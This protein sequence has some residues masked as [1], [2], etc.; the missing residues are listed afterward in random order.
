[1]DIKLKFFKEAL[2]HY[3][4]GRASVLA[5][6]HTH[7]QTA[8]EKILPNGTAYITDLGMTGIAD[9]I[10]GMEP[11]TCIQRARKQVLYRMEAAEKGQKKSVQGII[12]EIDG[13]SGRAVGI[14]R[15]C[16]IK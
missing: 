15:F 12:A 8:D 11:E 9:G 4:D 6:T 2:G 1:M 7:V 13:E 14:R 10:I 5:G 16:L 3:I